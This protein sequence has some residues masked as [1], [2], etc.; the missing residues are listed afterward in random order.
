MSSDIKL[1]AFDLNGVLV[2]SAAGWADACRRAGLPVRA[3][4]ANLANNPMITDTNTQVESG[5]EPMETLLDM[6]ALVTGYTPE[7]LGRIFEVWYVEM[8]PGAEKLIDYL[9]K[10][11]IP[12]A[13][14]ANVNPM[15]WSIL[16]TDDRFAPLM[17]LDHIFVS[18]K[19]GACKPS[20]EAF[21]YVEDNVHVDPEQ[22][23]YFDYDASSVDAAKYQYWKAEQ[24]V[25]GRNPAKQIALHL[26]NYG[27]INAQRVAVAPAATP[28]AH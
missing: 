11:S 6:M 5:L 28:Q 21:E 18:P 7:Q 19:M 27:L 17:R 26:T 10:K 23:L 16:S 25:F 12:T 3:E 14:V 22:I 13:L 24:I 1:V 4:I 20:L 2:Q 15:Q 9:K 8:T